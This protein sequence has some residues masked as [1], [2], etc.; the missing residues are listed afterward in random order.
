MYYEIDVR[1]RKTGGSIECIYSGDNRTVAINVMH[2]H[3]LQLPDYEWAKTFYEYQ[4]TNP[5][6]P[7]VAYMYYVSS[8]KDLH[9]VGKYTQISKG[10]I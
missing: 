10:G 1:N 5:D 6:G 4:E 9:G 8:P 7:P 3:N 2:R